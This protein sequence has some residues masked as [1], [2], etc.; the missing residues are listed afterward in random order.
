M[1]SKGILDSAVQRSCSRGGVGKEGAFERS[2]RESRGS[3]KMALVKNLTGLAPLI[4]TAHCSTWWRGTARSVR[5]IKLTA[6]V[7]LVARS[8][9][10]GPGRR[11]Q[12][13]RANAAASERS[14]ARGN[15]ATSSLRR[16]D[17]NGIV[18]RGEQ[19]RGRDGRG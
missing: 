14:V 1:K 18:G 11:G 3:L 5:R 6:V 16:G 17:G 13:A 4:R 10:R 2:E 15:D 8:G 12:P 19:G 7:S 9:R